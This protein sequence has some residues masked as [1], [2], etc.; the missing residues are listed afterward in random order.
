M[1]ALVSVH[2]VCDLPNQLS[3]LS[4]MRCALHAQGLE[5]E[6]IKSGLLPGDAALALKHFRERLA[7]LNLTAGSLQRDFEELAEATTNTEEES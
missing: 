3:V 4:N 2:F 7:H 1:S 5:L 6:R